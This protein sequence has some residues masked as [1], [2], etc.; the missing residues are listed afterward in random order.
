MT[1]HVCNDMRDMLQLAEMCHTGQDLDG[2]PA[3]R[4]VVPPPGQL[5]RPFLANYEMT[6][7]CKIVINL[8]TKVNKFRPTV[9]A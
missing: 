6:R 1:Q 8:R 9:H 7:N 4:Q 5:C 3:P 2:F